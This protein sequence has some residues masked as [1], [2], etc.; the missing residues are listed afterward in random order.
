MSERRLE[1][2]TKNSRKLY[3]ICVKWYETKQTL[4]E[5]FL[6]NKDIVSISHS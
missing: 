5:Y 4:W 2:Y 6:N 1:N 3:E